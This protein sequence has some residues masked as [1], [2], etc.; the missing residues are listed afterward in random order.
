MT[1]KQITIFKRNEITRG[2]DYYS[3]NAKK[4]FNAIYYLYQ[5][6]RKITTQHTQTKLRYSSLRKIMNLQKDN[7]YV[8]VI[9]NAIEELQSTLIKLNNFE[10]DGK[11]YKWYSTKFLNDAHVEKDKEIFVTLEIS[12]FFKKMMIANLGFT[13]LDLVKYLNK[14][15]TKYAM[16]I[17]EYLKSFEG[18]KYLD[19][20]QSHMIKLLG[21]ENS[22]SYS[23]YANLKQLVERQLIEIGNKSDL[24]QVRLFNSKLLA[25]KKIFRIRINPKSK[26]N[27]DKLETYTALE[28]LIKRF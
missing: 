28:G 12:T 16:K 26:K 4:C 17:Y 13:E 18:Y 24:N 27:A 9:N 23:N 22:K 5:K 15:R 3:L 6:N 25:K 20:P 10:L 21:L 7:N 14:F 8:E 2:A 1:D 11:K 19:V